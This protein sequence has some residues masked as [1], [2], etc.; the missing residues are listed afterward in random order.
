MAAT[1][2]GADVYLFGGVGADTGTESILHVSGD[3]WIFTPGNL[4]W[5]NLELTADCAACSYEN[6]VQ[7]LPRYTPVFYEHKD[8]LVVAE[9]QKEDRHVLFKTIRIRT[10]PQRIW[11]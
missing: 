8:R 7:P 4:M 3:L 1:P 10:L 2:V 6:A 9:I 11:S 5:H